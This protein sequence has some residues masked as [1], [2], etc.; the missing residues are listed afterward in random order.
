MTCKYLEGGGLPTPTLGTLVKLS[1]LHTRIQE[2]KN[3]GE[4]FPGIV[5]NG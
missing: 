1:L 4:S 3:Y 5:A 2:P